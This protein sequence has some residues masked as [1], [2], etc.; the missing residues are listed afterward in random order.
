MATASA[1]GCACARIA[2]VLVLLVG[3]GPDDRVNPNMRDTPGGAFQST[4]SASS[5]CGCYD[6]AGDDA[7][8][9]RGDSD[10]LQ[11]IG[12]GG[13]SKCSFTCQR[14]TDCTPIFG[15]TAK[16]DVTAGACHR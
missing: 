1:W 9:A 7:F 10:Q 14:N 5:D 12:F 13:G 16:C 11:R 6:D 2:V 15:A 3:C 4:C 8:C